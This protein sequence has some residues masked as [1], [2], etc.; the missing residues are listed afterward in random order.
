MPARTLMTYPHSQHCAPFRVPYSQ[1][2][3]PITFSF[4]STADMRQR[5]FFEIWQTAVININDNSLNFFTEYTRD[6]DIWQLDRT[7]K[8]TYGIRLFGAWPVAIGDVS[9]SYAQN[10]VVTEITV[11]MEYKIWQN[12]HDQTKIYVYS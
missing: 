6:I 3:E 5:H 4:Y 10:N 11:T 8:K 1:Q 7:G 12:N 9:Y 2:F